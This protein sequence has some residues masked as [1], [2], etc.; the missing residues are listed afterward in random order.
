MGEMQ[1]VDETTTWA[2]QTFG[3]DTRLVKACKKNG[4]VAP[5]LVQRH[6]V[7]CIMSGKDVLCRARTGAGK[8]AAYLLP[9]LHKTLQRKSQVA[10]DVQGMRCLILVPTNELCQQ[11]RR[12][13]G[14]GWVGRSGRE[15]HHRRWS[16]QFDSR[17]GGRWSELGS[18]RRP[19]L[20]R[21]VLNHR[22]ASRRPPAPPRPPGREP[23]LRAR[24]LLL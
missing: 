9:V 6:A 18:G 21:P 10:Y 19:S 12:G 22:P 13:R 15:E 5:L 17:V 16:V 20:G 11:V 3:L 8:T 2:T 24:I 7:P 23:T 1:E 14:R 4:W